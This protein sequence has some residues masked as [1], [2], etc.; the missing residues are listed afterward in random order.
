MKNDKIL[1]TSHV[2]WN[3]AKEYLHH[4]LPDVRNSSHNTVA[5]YRD[6]I[7]YYINY[8]EQEKLR[9]RKN[10]SFADFSRNNIKEYVDWML[11]KKSL[12][13][14]TCNLRLTA[15]HSLLEYASNEYKELMPAYLDVC[16]IKGIKTQSGPIEFF[17][18]SQMKALLTSPDTAKKT[19]RRNQL[20]LIILYDLALRVSE[21]LE[22]KVN[23]LHL[24]S[25][26]P[27]ATIYGKGRKYR[28]I[29]LM[30]KTQQHLK[31]YLKEFHEPQ[32]SDSYLFYAIT[33]GEQHRLSSDT[34]ESMLKRYSQICV[35]KG[36][37]MPPKS[38]CHMVRKTRA[39]DLYRNGVP[40][41]HIQQLLG[42]EN[43]S[44]T[45]GF[46]AFATLDTLAKSMGRTNDDIIEKKW[47][48]KEVQ[49]IIHSL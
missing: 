37:E 24:G 39:M 33:H 21:L 16:S 34:V 18:S 49:N 44:T 47:K 6:S 31:R 13:P 7:N 40:L 1:G 19:E 38:N 35:S 45:S 14:K 43:L 30:D 26:V 48:S 25:A 23:S 4:Y 42:H 22:L 28:N 27:Y 2:F 8:L 29:P 36:T 17:E 32:Q 3:T 9:L 20:M 10:I 5:A 11:N 41:T 12:A 15:I 46:Y